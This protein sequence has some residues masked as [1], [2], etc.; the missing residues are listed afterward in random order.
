MNQKQLADILA[1]K[2]AVVFDLDGVILD[3]LKAHKNH[4]K[5]VCKHYDI[6]F[7]KTFRNYLKSKGK[8]VRPFRFKSAYKFFLGLHNYYSENYTSLGLDWPAIELI[9]NKYFF[10]FT[11][12]DTVK[13][14]GGMVDLISELKGAGLKVGLF[15]SNHRSLVMERLDGI[16]FD[17]IVCYDDVLNHKPASDGLFK[18][19]YELGVNRDD[20]VYVGDMVSDSVA[21][22]HANVD[23][24]GVT[25]G[26]CNRKTLIDCPHIAVVHS[27]KKL[28]KVLLHSY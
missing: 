1:Q 4:L 16:D 7:K 28:K 15:T 9:A 25:Y 10:E 24:I 17:S 14:F 22:V 5:A 21:A 13:L 8:R 23:F 18:C 6:K 19:T 20:V 2:K 3:S 26:Y 27:P 11:N 12:S